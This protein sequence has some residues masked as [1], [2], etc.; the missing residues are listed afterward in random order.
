[1]LDCTRL[2]KDEG[3]CGERSSQPPAISA[4]P[5]KKSDIMSEVVLAVLASAEY[6]IECNQMIALADTRWSRRTKPS[7][8]TES[9][10]IV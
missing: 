7:R 8:F 5:A 4:T 2:L 9:W 10:E 1:M 6:P 3:P